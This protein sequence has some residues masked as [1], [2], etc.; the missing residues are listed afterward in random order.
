MPPMSKGFGEHIEDYK[1]L[2]FLGKGGFGCVYKAK[3]LNTRI[4]VAIKMI[5]K[6]L[7][8]RHGMIGRVRDEVAIHSRL[9]HQSILK[10]YTYFEDAN[11]VYMVLELCPNGDLQRFLKDHYP[12]GLSEDEAARVI[13]QVLEGLL[14]LHNH[15][16]LHRDMSPSNLL[17]TADMQVKIADFGLATLSKPNEN[18]MTLCGT[19]NYISPEVA[20]RSSHGP[21]ADVWGL[22]CLLYTLLVGKAPFDTD[23]VKSTLTRVV[24]AD[25]TIPSYLSDKAKDLISRLL[26]K[27]PHDRIELR[28]I[29][30]H[31]FITSNDQ[32]F[33][34]KVLLSRALSR[35]RMADSGLGKTMSSVD[36]MPRGRSRS[37]ERAS[38]VPSMSTPL[39]PQFTVRSDPLTERNNY[40]NNFAYQSKRNDYSREQTSVLSGIP[41]PRSRVFSRTSQNSCEDINRQKNDKQRCREQAIESLKDQ[42]VN[43]KLQIPPLNSQRLLPTRHRTKNAVLTILD[44]GEVCI[45]FIKKKNS[46]M[47]RIGEVCR[48]SSDGLRIAIYKLKEST[49]IGDEPPPLPSYGADNIYSY[50]SLPSRHHRKYIYAARF[51][52]LVK[53][54]TPKV[55]LYT[56]RAKCQF[57]ENGPHPDCEIHFYNGIKITCVDG[58]VKITDSVGNSYGEGEVPHELEEYYEHYRECY[59]RCLLLETTLTSLES[60]TGHSYF[61]AIIGRKPLSAGSIPSLQGKENI[62]RMT[63]SPP[64]MP[65]FDATCSVMSAVTSRS[66][67]TT[68]IR[69]SQYA[70]NRVIIP[71]IGVAIQLP[72]GDVKIE[73]KDGSAITVRP[74]SRGGGVLYEN[75][76]GAITKYSKNHHQN[77][78]M[79][80]EVKEKLRHL[81]TVIT[82]LVQPKHRNIR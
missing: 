62:S 80:Y 39:A 32:K 76:N 5:D 51:V 81:P 60:A 28:D 44:S 35:D 33:Q 9:K 47:E 4:D 57:M 10:L 72:N 54:K 74:D 11:Y 34:E 58:V 14:Y 73:Y 55:T 37:E 56:E 66:K 70:F 78:Q 82:H 20:T 67:K 77:V 38:M 7:M 19:P 12:Q 52:K 75:D 61:P 21:Q 71:G 48:I 16:I 49:P 64:V 79:P 25:Y 29:L 1:V 24:M 68:S 41:P 23:G 43:T 30:K 27:N 63:N 36:R 31:P 59:K 65:S 3:C 42:D 22:G 50:E 46:N 40:Q 6:N 26:K 15:K 69:S 8:Q 17:L 45:E 18:H 53:A 13:K 2:E